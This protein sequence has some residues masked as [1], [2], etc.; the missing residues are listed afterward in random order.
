MNA[1]DV[2]GWSDFAVAAAGAGAALTGLIFVAVS[3]NLRGILESA[4]LPGRAAQTVALLLCVV[5]VALC[6]LVPGQSATALGLEMIGAAGVLGLA[7]VFWAAGTT[8]P[9][10]APPYWRWSALLTVLVPVALFLIGG[11][12]VA[13][14]SGGGLYWVFAAV[15]VGTAAGVLNAW[16]LLVEINR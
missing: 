11:T 12:S 1:Y 13:V 15:V 14:G 2:A 5:V 10:D 8:G 9:N 6:L 3:L 4:W 16:V 7:T